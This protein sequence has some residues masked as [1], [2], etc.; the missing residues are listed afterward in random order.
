[1]RTVSVG[2]LI[3]TVIGALTV[4]VVVAATASLR[5]ADLHDPFTIVV[6]VMLGGLIVFGIPLFLLAWLLLTLWARVMRALVARPQ[7]WH[8]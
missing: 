5:G 4:G 7:D 8:P 1:M 6:T 2:A 3:A